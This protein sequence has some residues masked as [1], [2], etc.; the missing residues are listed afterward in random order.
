MVEEKDWN[1]AIIEEFRANEG[2]VGGPFEGFPL[3]LLH[4]TG[5][6]SGQARVNPLAYQVDGD[7]LMVFASKAGAPTNPDWFYNVIANPDVTVEVGTETTSARATV[8]TGE[9]RDRIWRRQVESAPTFGEYEEKS[10][11]TIPV[12]ALDRTG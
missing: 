3:L 5:A 10:G 7:R 6:K 12:V 4:T 8:L 1:R 2:K 9:E 11:R